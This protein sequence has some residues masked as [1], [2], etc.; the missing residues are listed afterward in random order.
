ME[1]HQ[2]QELSSALKEFGDGDEEQKLIFEEKILKIR[3]V[4]SA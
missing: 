2:R 3:N 4:D 1:L